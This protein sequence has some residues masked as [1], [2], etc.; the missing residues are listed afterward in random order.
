MRSSAN[1]KRNGVSAKLNST[2]SGATW[3]E[4]GRNHNQHSQR[5]QERQEE[6]QREAMALGM[7]HVFVEMGL[8]IVR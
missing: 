2:A 5:R 3:Q 1:P 8:K 6:K 4:A 7:D